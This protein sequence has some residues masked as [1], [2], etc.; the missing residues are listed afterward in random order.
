MIGLKITHNKKEVACALDSG[1]I[2]VLLTNKSGS[3]RITCAGTD[4]NSN[5]YT[6]YGENVK[7]GDSISACFSHLRENDL[8]RPIST[9]MYASAYNEKKWYDM[10]WGKCAEKSFLGN[11]LGKAG[12]AYSS[13]LLLFDASPVPADSAPFPDFRQS[14][15]RRPRIGRRL[16][17]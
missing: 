14:A 3:Y 7:P 16:F 4:E 6:W 1:I 9:K 12:G 10:K 2:S 5:S 8:C 17:L 15:I 11:C 13:R